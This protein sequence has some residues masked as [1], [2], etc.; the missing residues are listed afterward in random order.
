MILV[1][2]NL[3][4]LR[5]RWNLLDQKEPFTFID[6]INFFKTAI[7]HS[8]VLFSIMHDHAVAANYE[9][10]YSLLAKIEND[11]YEK[12]LQQCGIAGFFKKLQTSACGILINLTRPVVI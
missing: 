7:R 1:I 12:P 10:L 4:S 3:Y 8:V 6:I 5:Y 2:A 11:E 9:F